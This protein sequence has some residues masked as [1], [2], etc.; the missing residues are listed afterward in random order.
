MLRPGLQ[1]SVL[2]LVLLATLSVSAQ[3][4]YRLRM[5]AADRD[6]SFLSEELAV[7]SEFV[8][9]YSCSDY[10]NKLAPALRAKGY[11]TASLDSVRYDSTFATAV[12][13]IGDM[14]KWADINTKQVDAELLN[15][16]G[17]RENVFIN[18]SMDF[19]QLKN[20]QEKMLEYLENNGYP[21]AKVY[22]DSMQ[23]EEEKISAML[24]VEKGHQY[25][26]DSIKINGDVKI[27]NAFLQKYLDLPDGSLYNREKL[28]R[29]SKKL[30]DL[31]YVQ[32]EKPS[33][34]SLL[35][36]GSVLNLYLK[37]KRSSQVNVLLGFLPNNDQLTSK[38]LLV[39]GEANINLRNALGQGET[40]GLNW[41]QLQVKSPRLNLVYQHPYLFNTQIGLDFAFDMFRK[42]S[43]FLNVNLQLGAQYMLS[44]TQ[45]GKLFIQKF[46]TILNAVNVATILQTHQLPE[47]ADVNSV[48][49]GIDYDFN[50]TDYRFNPKKG[51]ELRI[52]GSVG[53]KNIKK[54]N[55]IVALK[56]PNDL[57]YDFS[58]LYDTVKL[59]S[60]QF[61]VRATA[62]KY[63]PL[64]RQSTIKAAFNGGIFQSANIFR[65]EL[66]QIGG[67]KLLRGFDEE[68]QYL[69]KFAIGT[70]EYHYLIG[71]N[72][73]FYTLFDGGWGQNSSLG[74]SID[75]TYFGA[76]LGLAFETKVGIF[77][78]AWAVG[79]RSDTQFNLRQSKI[80]FGFVN[81]F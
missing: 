13:F 39:T 78:L 2:L 76:G 60:Y 73:Y 24:K 68:S 16:V 41:Q 40:I 23:I 32:E 57:N 69:S 10:I 45:S 12:I 63:F 20:W 37:Q 8:N 27:S 79:K 74:R 75:Y 21:F 59:K 4:S 67:Y 22:L 29:I 26:I 81:Y 31:P 14:Y 64:G 70:A 66:F 46:Q 72:S 47:D 49:V 6:S 80:H 42:D 1:I 5:K 44:T 48:N 28:K 36:M 25:K 61:R 54:N 58:S 55:Q 53:T 56:D 51:N 34:I 19:E 43:T 17:W 9:R 50:N 52:I 77:N 11:V 18:K 7:P 15:A 33:D 35:S 30:L 71:M 38:K 3:N 65:N 62:A